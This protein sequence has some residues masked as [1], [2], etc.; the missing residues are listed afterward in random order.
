MN[1]V[2]LGPPGAGK[3]TQAKVLK[4]AL[5][6][7]HISTGDIFREEMSKNTPLGLELKSFVD[8]GNLVPDEIVIKIIENK[9]TTDPKVAYGY[10]LDGFPRTKQQ[11]ENLDKILHKIKKPFD[12]VVYMEATLPV[13]VQRLT[14][15]RVCRKCGELF[16]IKNK[17]PRKEGI[18]DLCGGELY[19]RPDDNELTIKKRMDV[20]LESTSPIIEYYKAKNNLIKVDAD[21]DAN[22]V[23]NFLMNIFHK[24]GKL[25]QNQDKRRN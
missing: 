12:Y 4:E 6:I 17:L 7:M 14:G 19:Q 3:G 15:R 18:C 23:K 21:K 20:Y 16:H 24:D 11:A 1:L 25:D 2:L 13:I 22:Y 5:D 8:R 9:L 10:L